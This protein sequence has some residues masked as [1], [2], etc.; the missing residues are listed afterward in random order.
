MR[1][2]NGAQR[3]DTFSPDVA[4]RRADEGSNEGGSEMDVRRRERGRMYK[5]DMPF[6]EFYLKKRL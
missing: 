6:Y 2:E 5:G 3:L 1:C 4:I